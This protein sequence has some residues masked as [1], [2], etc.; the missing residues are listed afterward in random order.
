MANQIILKRSS[1]A[2]KAPLVAQL[3]LGEI[4]INTHDGKI[5]I[6]KDNGVPTVVEIGGVTSVNTQG[7]DVVLGTADI[8]ESGSN[9]Y[10]T[11]ARARASIV[12]GSGISYNSTTGAVS[13]SQNLTTTGAP[14]FAGV[15]LTD[16][17]STKSIVPSLSNTYDLGTSAN[18]WRH[19]Y[20][21]PG[22]LYVNGKQVLTEASGTMTF[23]ADLDQNMRVTTTGTGLL[24]FGSSTTGVNVDGTLQL[25]AGKRIISSD[26]VKVQFGDDVELNGNKVIGLGVP[27]SLTD[28]ATK[29]YVDVSISAISTS[30]IQQGNSSIAVV[31]SGTGT[32]TVTVDGTTALAV[33]ASGVVISG[34][35]TVNGT[36]TTVNSNTIALADNII[37]LNSDT[38]GVPTQNA[39]V[40]IER[41]D[42]ANVQLRWNESALK[43]SFTNDGAVYFP[44]ATGTDTLAEGAT[45]LYFTAG[46]A[47]NAINA[48]SSTG[49]SYNS[50]SGAIS[51]GSIPNT[52]LVNNSIVIN[53]ASVALGGTRT[54]AVGDIAGAA[55]DTSVTAA[56]ATAASDATAKVL[57]ETNA[58]VTAVSGAAATAATDA[59]TKANA[60]Q[61]AAIAAAATDATTKANAAQAA[62]IAAAA[63]DATSKVAAEATARDTAISSAVAT[64]VAA[65]NTAISTAVAGKDNTDEITEGTANLYFTAARAVTATASAVSGA[66]STAASDA[67]AKV[68]TETNRATTAEA[69]AIATAATD[70][71]SK[72]AAEATA[73]DTAISSAVAAEAS[74]RSSADTTLQTNINAKL[75]S[76]SY[77]AADV[78]AKMVTVDGAGSLL[79][80]DLLDGQ[81]GAYYASAASV[82][83]AVSTAASDATTKANAAQAAA[84]AA[85]ATDATT[86]ANAAQAAAVS[87]AASDATSKVAAE[88]GLRATGDTNTLSSANSFTT[89]AISNLVNGASAAF[90]TLKEIQDAM[91]TDAE[92]AS[93]IAA[94]SNVASAT[95]LQTAR[96]IQGVAFDGTAAITVVTAGAGISV[97]GTTVTNTITN[98]NQLTNGSGFI[99]G[100]TETSTLATVT[101][102][103]AT[104]TS[105]LSTGAL[106]VT[107]AI[108]ATGEVTAYYSDVN[109]KKDI[110]EITDPI[111]KVMALRGVTFR[112]NQT[113]LDLGIIDKEEVGVIAQE[114][115]AVLPQLVVPSAFAGFKTVK[116]DKLTALLLEAVKAQQLQIDA[117]SAQVAK[118]GGSATT[119]L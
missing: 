95:K 96:T 111:A 64:E 41:G 60:A 81:Q 21:G 15:T 72:V 6:K 83:T 97:S 66:V 74:L 108:T 52:S 35:M 112:P 31:D 87:T 113:A 20:V 7:G 49:V 53:G 8:A 61:A 117:L 116:Y 10:F 51:L 80:A 25:A 101:A 5:Y 85:A 46:R 47:R 78:L 106:T 102:R 14:T 71:T 67:T 100:Y 26:G 105:A 118:L 63:T 40:E 119:E 32:I 48:S 56:I 39:G 24:Q 75:A 38:V 103:G 65:R 28:A 90:D 29:G 2:G 88:A 59:T 4:A 114:V 43:W 30:S 86:K 70:A 68:L 54:L 55:T 44:L 82:T 3:A 45:N 19:V 93:A 84:I 115:E 33:T 57:V 76:S 94:I 18:P 37:T 27:T 22:S 98:N 11:T 17:A 9:Q 62:A 89:T 50:A 104:T 110:V 79:D 34:N 23:T 92:L 91:A 58:R 77:T 12:A 42:E 69:A 107:G 16:T 36:T 99:T 13:T 73:R 1:T 109:L